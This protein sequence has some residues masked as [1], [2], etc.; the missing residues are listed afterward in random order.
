MFL[1]P[2]HPNLLGT[3]GFA[4]VD[5]SQALARLLQAGPN[6]NN[7]CPRPEIATLDYTIL[8]VMKLV[9]L[10]GALSNTNY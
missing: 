8:N 7:S 9:F 2:R 3:G 4:R 10:S 1:Y 6:S 5:L